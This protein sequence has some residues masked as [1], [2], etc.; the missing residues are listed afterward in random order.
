MKLSYNW[1]KEYVSIDADAETLAAK[2]TM[3][4][5]E[6]GSVKN[7]NGDIV[8]E[9]EIT[10][11]RPDCLNMLGLA[12]EA[13]AIFGGKARMPE[14]IL[15]GD[16]RAEK[17]AAVKCEIKEPLLCPRYTAR[18][19]RDVKVRESI[20]RIPALLENIGVRKVNNV[21]DVIN[22]CLMESGQPMHAFDM[23][24]IKGAAIE[25]RLA[26]KGERI[27]TIDGV[28]RPLETDMLVI[29]DTEKPIAIA[30]VM[31]GKDTEVTL[32]TKN[33]LLESAYFDPI[34]IRRTSRA[35]GLASDSSYRFERGVD[36]GAVV[37]SS[38]RAV[39]LIIEQAGGSTAGYY[40]SGEYGEKPKELELDVARAG[41]LLGKELA[42]EETEALLE[43]LGM[44]VCRTH[45][46][47]LKV[48][49]PTF[50]GDIYREVDLIEEV[51]RI[52]GYDRIPDT[53]PTPAPWARRKST[54]RETAEKI[55][56]LLCS[57]GLNE[58]MTYSLVN[59]K[60]QSNFPDIAE[61]SVKIMNP[62]SAE[63]EMLTPHLIDGMLKAITWNLN[64]GNKDLMFFECGKIYRRDLD[65]GKFQ[66]I[67]VLALGMTGNVSKN[68]IDGE[69]KADIYRVKGVLENLAKHM[70]ICFD[71]GPGKIS[72][73]QNAAII[74]LG[75]EKIGFSGGVSGEIGEL[76]GISQNVFVAQ[77]EL[78]GVYKAS[79]LRARYSPVPRFPSSCRDISVLCDI[80][81]TAA[82]IKTIAE[83][84]G[85]KM[86]EKVDIVD[87]YQGKQIPPDMKSV[88]F[89]VTYGLSDRTLTDREIEQAHSRI[90]KELAAQPGITFR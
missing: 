3:A 30:G 67:P 37:T 66:E 16:K 38:D 51:A 77:V 56:K 68:W 10:S 22:F 6:V 15:P 19:I 33:I 59:E 47:K 58:I 34:S 39:S 73:F 27:V 48:T 23:D 5:S 87:M 43:R 46:G 28:E 88:T 60:A 74:S 49:V 21:V 35:L 61:R 90:K 52:H 9:L 25:V 2:L 36:T 18:V 85:G 75:E 8:M 71:F 44:G 12:R 17:S 11:N 80:C 1:I 69:K 70:R 4:G 76:Y 45:P 32:N 62:L 50:R 42:Q 41:A 31:G 57:M 24:K 29:A 83:S 89:S 86:V 53:V 20:G 79:I 64:R 82:S 14:V 40:D 84:I 54:E 7:V 55:K 72:G 26:R 78:P 81:V 13:A 65:N 63:Q